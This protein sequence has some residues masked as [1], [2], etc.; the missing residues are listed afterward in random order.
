MAKRGFTLVELSIVLVIIGLLTGGILVA[1]S[2]INAE[3]SQAFIRQI[4]QYDSVVSNFQ[5]KFNSLP[6][7]TTLLTPPGDG[8]GIINDEGLS[9]DN[10]SGETGAFWAHL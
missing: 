1:K 2:M 7:D 4:Q 9:D 8:N 6:G 10:Y 3:R 5:R